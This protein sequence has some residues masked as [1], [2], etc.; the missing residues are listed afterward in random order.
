MLKS[1]EGVPVKQDPSRKGLP[2]SLSCECIMDHSPYLFVL[3]MALV[4]DIAFVCTVGT[5]KFGCQ[6][7]NLGHH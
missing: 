4:L 5:A 1:V 7:T 2:V 6:H 3:A